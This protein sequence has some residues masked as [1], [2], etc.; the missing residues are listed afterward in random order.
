MILRTT[1]SDVAEQAQTGNYVGTPYHRLDCQAFVEKV[2]ED[3]GVRKPDG[4]TYNWKGS[5]SMYR[6][7]IRWRG[8]VKECLDKFG[9]IPL[10]AFVFIIKHDGGEVNRGYHDDLGNATHVGLFVGSNY[11][12][13]Q[14]MDSQPTG[15]VQYRKLSLFTHVGLMDMI[16]YSSAPLPKEED[17]N[18]DAITAIHTIRN[19][20]SSDED[21]LKALV[22]LTKY[23]KEVKL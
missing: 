4:T 22:T 21:C 5:N 20:E 14:C 11:T 19:P 8:T 3:L 7:H 6:N 9:C 18:S 2:L 23:I 15:G 13:Y 12:G 16:D 17:K 10:G 1:G